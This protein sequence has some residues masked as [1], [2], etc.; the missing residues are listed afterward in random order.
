MKEIFIEEH[1]RLTDELIE[2]GMDPAQAHDVAAD[3]A[4]DATRDR[5]ADM[6]D[7]ARQRAKDGCE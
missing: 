7:R 3:R 1:E 5:L 4:M 2:D 6:A